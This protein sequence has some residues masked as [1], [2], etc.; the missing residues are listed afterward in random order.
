MKFLNFAFQQAF[1]RYSRP[2]KPKVTTDSNEV[3]FL[4]LPYHSRDPSRKLIQK[5]FQEHI[6]RPETFHKTFAR[7]CN[8][9]LENS[10]RY[11]WNGW[12]RFISRSVPLVPPTQYEPYLTELLNDDLKRIPI[13]RLIVA[14][15]RAPNLKNILFPR[16]VEAKC[17]SARP[18]STI[19]T[20][21][22]NGQ[23]TPH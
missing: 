5:A 8:H 23:E 10:I 7:A 14:Y 2:P 6:F 12:D 21:L 18:V 1:R 17:P 3:V 11:E 16:H 4:H 22:L 15:R 13:N 19:Q 9:D 20:E